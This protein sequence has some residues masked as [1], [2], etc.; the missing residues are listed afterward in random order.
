MSPAVRRQVWVLG[1]A[2]A[3]AATGW[4]LAP[5][6]A[7]ARKGTLDEQT[8]AAWKQEFRIPRPRRA[9]DGV[10]D[11]AGGA[12]SAVESLTDESST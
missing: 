6:V 3:A 1:G 4:V 7:M 5:W 8:V 10:R 11:S 12:T 9:P 2:V